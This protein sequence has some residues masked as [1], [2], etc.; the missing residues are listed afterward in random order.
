MS[1]DLL[2]PFGQL[3]SHK[4]GAEQAWGWQV[5]AAGSATVHVV[6][7]ADKPL[8]WGASGQVGNAMS[9]PGP[10]GMLAIGLPGPAGSAEPVLLPC[11]QWPIG[12][13]CGHE[14]QVCLPSDR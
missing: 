10:V 5:C 7:A 13:A 8:D 14:W 12:T 6:H 3:N 4:S 11:W 1:C 2:T 9:W